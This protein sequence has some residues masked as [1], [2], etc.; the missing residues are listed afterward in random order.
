MGVV[1]EATQLSLQRVVALKMLA[2]EI[3]TDADAQERF[4][5]E[6][7]MQA[8]IDHPHI[9]Q[10]YDAGSTD[11][12]LFIAMRLIHGE[13]LKSRISAQR[14]PATA[15]LSM[16]RPVADALDTAHA[17][18]LV[19]RDVKPQNILV[20][21][22]GTAYLSDFGV[23]HAIGQT[24]L[25]AEGRL[26]GTP[27]YMSP[28]QAMGEEATAE[29]DVYSFA[30]VLYEG[31]TGVVPFRASSPIAVIRQQV[32]ET[33]PPPTTIRPDL[34]GAVDEAFGRA[35][36]KEPSERPPSAFELMG[37]VT[38]ALAGETPL[39]VTTLPRG[40]ATP[41]RAAPSPA[42]ARGRRLHP[43]GAAAVTILGLAAF[44]TIVAWDRDGAGGSQP[45]PT[46]SVA[47]ERPTITPMTRRDFLEERNVS[48]GG[49]AEQVLDQ[50]GAAIEANLRVRGRPRQLP[51]TCTMRDLTTRR[52]VGEV[53]ALTTEGEADLASTTP[54]WIAFDPRQG[55]EY[56]ATVRVWPSA[57]AAA[58]IA[59]STGDYREAP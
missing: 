8:A 36:A 13:T 52:T 23:A 10:V 29:S 57:E 12:G 41:P 20:D 22:K 59:T 42:H 5:R 30:T 33:P 3:G 34:P 14:L 32:W 7:L 43:G 21:A 44:A 9:V 28:E 58:P 54:C 35:L 51:V 25:T 53:R 1:Y 26:V 19:H 15:L 17:S 31:L 38:A 11:A 24:S 37:D 39:P 4:R 6:A 47:L 56:R 45:S 2:A 16:L 46:P 55:H 18:G 27:G 48:V 40:V 50:V 49:I